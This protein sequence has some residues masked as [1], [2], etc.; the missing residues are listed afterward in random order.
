M[1]KITLLIAS[2]LV[3]YIAN[4]QLTN[5]EFIGKIKNQKGEL[6][7]NAAVKLIYTPCAIKYKLFSDIKGNFKASNIEVGGPYLLRIELP[8]YRVY[9][10]RQMF[11]DLGYN[12]NI[13]IVLEAINEKDAIIPSMN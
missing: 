5:A 1:K 7:Q 6:I 11:F 10:K 12:E 13:N 2:L 8:G 3:I 9:E 4:A